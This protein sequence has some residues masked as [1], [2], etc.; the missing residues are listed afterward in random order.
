[1]LPAGTSAQY[2]VAIDSKALGEGMA[3]APTPFGADLPTPAVL[4]E[5]TP[6]PTESAGSG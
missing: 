1:L 4:P 6:A 2:A 5:E 3:V